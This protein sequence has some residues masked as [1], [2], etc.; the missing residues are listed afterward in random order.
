[1]RVPSEIVLPSQS[2]V[3]FFPSVHNTELLHKVAALPPICRAYLPV[4][5]TNVLPVLEVLPLRSL[6]LPLPFPPPSSPP[7]TSR[8]HAHYKKPCGGGNK[9]PLM[10]NGSN[11]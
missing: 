10:M 7:I 1:M 3:I 2:S 4:M 11:K 9:P 5:R 6:S 8:R